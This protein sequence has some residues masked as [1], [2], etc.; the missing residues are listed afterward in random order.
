MFLGV[1]QGAAEIDVG[2]GVSPGPTTIAP[3]GSIIREFP[4][5][6]ELYVCVGVLYDF[7]PSGTGTL[8]MLDVGTIS[9]KKTLELRRPR[10]DKP[11]HFRTMNW[12]CTEDEILQVGVKITTETREGW[13][14]SSRVVEVLGMCLRAEACD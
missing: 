8:Q 12:P 4:R 1:Q 5:G 14:A 3:K 6:A 10:L 7:V 13:I 2:G 11:V 9:G